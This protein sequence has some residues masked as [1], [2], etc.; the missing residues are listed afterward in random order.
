L[1]LV[2][3]LIGTICFFDHAAT[4]IAVP[5]DTVAACGDLAREQASPG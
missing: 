3:A 1:R 5:N 4:T 2:A